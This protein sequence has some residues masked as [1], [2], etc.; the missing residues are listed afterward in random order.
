MFEI[1]QHL[2]LRFVFSS[3]ISALIF[4]M[5]CIL[6]SRSLF[7]LLTSYLGYFTRLFLPF[8]LSRFINLGLRIPL[9]GCMDL[10]SQI[11]GIFIIIQFKAF[12]TFI[13]IFS[14]TYDLFRSMSLNSQTHGHTNFPGMSQQSTKNWVALDVFTLSKF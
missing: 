6:H 9:C 14:L 13:F 1:P 11:G 10:I 4:V 3:L 7:I 5:S 12:L 8:L 2:L